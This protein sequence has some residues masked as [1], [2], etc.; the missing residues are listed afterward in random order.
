[1]AKIALNDSLPA[2]PEAVFTIPPSLDPYGL[3]VGS[4][5][6]GPPTSVAMDTNRVIWDGLI[7]P[8]TP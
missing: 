6:V 1:M 5:L 2:L 3:P 7:S 8:P 4:R